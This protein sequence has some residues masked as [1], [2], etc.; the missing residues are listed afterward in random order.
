MAK[1]YRLREPSDIG[2]LNEA[3]R[4]AAEKRRVFQQGIICI[5]DDDVQIE[6]EAK[7]NKEVSRR[8]QLELLWKI[9]LKNLLVKNRLPLYALHDKSFI[10]NKLA[11]SV[12]RATLGKQIAEELLTRDYESV[13]EFG[14]GQKFFGFT[15]SALADALSEENFQELTLDKWIVLYSQAK[16]IGAKKQDLEKSIHTMREH[17]VAYTD[18]E[19][20]LGAPW[21]NEEIVNDFIYYLMDFEN[22]DLPYY[23][24]DHLQNSKQVAFYERVTGNW[25]IENKANYGNTIAGTHTWG[26]HNYNALYIIESMLNLREIKLY[27]HNNKFDETS[28]IAALEKQRLIDEEFKSWIWQSEDRQW[29]V[30]DAYNQ[31]FDGLSVAQYDGTKLAFAEKNPDIE[32]FDYQKNAVAQIISTPN[33]LL[34]F[35]VGAGKTYIM[36][37]AAMEMRQQGISRKNLFVVPNNIVG[38]WEEMFLRLYPKARVLTVDPKSFKPQMRNKILMQI[39]DGDYDGIIMAYSCFEFIKLS[40]THL[41]QT[42]EEFLAKL[43]QE[44]AQICKKRLFLLTKHLD[45]EMDSIRDSMSKLIKQVNVSAGDV[46][47][48]QLEINTLFLDEAHNFKNVPLKTHLKNVRGVNTTG[49]VKCLNMLHKVRCVQKQNNGRGAVFATGTP[50]CNSIADAF[51]MQLYLQ[52][53]LLERNNLHTFDNWVKTFAKPEQSFEIDVNVSSFRTVRRFA[54]FFNLP[55]LSKMFSA[56]SA[57]YSVEKSGLPEF[58]YYQDT[59]IEQSA[60]MKG[61]MKELCERTEKIRNKDVHPTKDNMLKVTTDGRSA[62]LD[63]TLV[64]KHQ[65]YD[66][67][68]KIVNCVANAWNIYNKYVG[69]SQLIFCD[70]STPKGMEFSVYAEIKRQLSRLG[71][72]DKEIAFVHSYHSEVTRLKLYEDVNCGKVRVLIGSTFKLGIGANVQSKLKAIHHLDVPWRPADMVQREGRILRRG[73]EYNEVFIYRYIIEGSFDAYSW[74]ILETKQRFISQFLTGKVQN[75]TT[76]DLEDSVLSYAEVKALALA[77]PQMKQL[78]EKEN[79]LRNLRIL[80][81]KEVDNRD[82]LRAQRAELS[83]QST[84]LAKLNA[85]SVQ[86]LQYILTQL[87]IDKDLIV[88]TFENIKPLELYVPLTELGRIGEFVVQSPEKQSDKKPFVELT[89]LGVSYPLEIGESAAGNVRRFTNF[90]NKFAQTVETQKEQLENMQREITELEQQLSLPL[91]YDQKVAACEQEVDALLNSIR[92]KM[93]E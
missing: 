78:A 12:D 21:I 10:A 86:N 69:C 82:L 18:I 27:D 19:V 25:S 36:I 2:E 31:I 51:V 44:K 46:T 54:R 56:I 63:L 13:G 91:V 76:S 93:P 4:S 41:Q 64:G 17:N 43:N 8:H 77:E 5:S 60:D 42:F 16:A 22:S 57:F 55:E 35:D 80:H 30:E 75:R 73:N 87:Q 24:K 20:S 83:R 50:L 92:D 6:R 85:L 62:T 45:R 47:F 3:A 33:T 7:P 15:Q 1:L 32:L 9:E 81:M 66:D 59:L 40:S 79:E 71:I 52:Y 74:Q 68:S 29:E 53:D 65:E 49:S 58:T 70:N 84:E 48:D 34:A 11:K 37:A 23:Y 88:E 67:S 39:R 89:R 61:F 90:F 72:P 38:Q 14:D 28:T 26:T